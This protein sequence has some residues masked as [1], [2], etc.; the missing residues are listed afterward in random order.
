M[1]LI[2]SASALLSLVAAAASASSSSSAGYDHY[3]PVRFSYDELV[4]IGRGDGEKTFDMNEKFWKTL[5]NVGMVSITNVPD[6]NKKSMFKTMEECI[7]NRKEIVPPEFVLDGGTKRLTVPTK[8]DNGIVSDLFA[9]LPDLAEGAVDGICPDFQKE[10]KTFR[11]SIQMVADAF[12][13]GLGL[14]K[15]Q[16]VM[17][18]DDGIDMTIEDVVLRGNHLEHFHSYYTND[19]EWAPHTIDWH[20]DQGLML[21]FTPGRQDDEVTSGFYI[22][23]DKATVEVDFDEA[24]DDVVIMLG[25]GIDQYFNNIKNGDGT[26]RKEE[27]PPL[28][29]VPHALTLPSTNVESG[30]PRIWYG[31]MVLP[32]NNAIVPASLDIVAEHPEAVPFTFEDMRKAMIAGED[33]AMNLGCSNPNQVAVDLERKIFDRRELERQDSSTY[34]RPYTV[35]PESTT[36]RLGLDGSVPHICGQG[37]GEG[38]ELNCWQRCMDFNNTDYKD[39]CESEGGCNSFYNG[40]PHDISPEKCEAVGQ[41]AMCMHNYTN[42]E[43]IKGYHN[44]AYFLQCGQPMTIATATMPPVKCQDDPE[45]EYVYT[46]K[47]G[48][49]KDKGGC[50]FVALK[51]KKRCQKTMNG[52][53]VAK[54]CGYTCDRTCEDEA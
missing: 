20:T 10:S 17:M 22:I 40:N 1:K 49:E 18:T 14:F 34:Q 3:T 41:V 23:K 19:D 43:W 8:T 31:R 52:M 2:V 25:D 15:P 46:D 44:H 54:S 4:S 38:L 9:G 16:H 5:Q 32:P 7:H 39:S 13:S 45:F 21:L 51:P 47:K 35:N 12:A 30:R 48:N 53:K 6:F 33:T 27:L 37:V 24:I 50:E 26:A 42:T 28:R 36:R 11:A 29:A